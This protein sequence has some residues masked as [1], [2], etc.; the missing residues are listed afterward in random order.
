MPLGHD[1][2]L[3]LQPEFRRKL[4]IANRVVGKLNKKVANYFEKILQAT[5]LRTATRRKSFNFKYLAMKDSFTNPESE[6]FR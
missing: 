3:A 5:Q 2:S 1:I 6:E 4:G